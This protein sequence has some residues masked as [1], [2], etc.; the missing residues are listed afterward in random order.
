[1]AASSSSSS[2]PSSL[3][4]PNINF[5]STTT[6]SVSIPGIFLP[7]NRLRY[8]HN[9]PLRIR[10][11]RDDN[12][13]VEDREKAVINGNGSVRLNGNGA[14]RKSINNGDLNGNGRLN[15]SLVKYVNGSVTEEVSKKREE[16]KR[17]KR[18]EDIGQEDAWFK[19]TQQKQQV[20]VSVAPGGRWSR[21]KTYST[22]Q[23]SLEIWG[24]V[25]TF[26]FRTWLSGQKFSY[27]G[28]MTEEKKVLR[29]KVLA[30][31]LKE[32][33]LRLGPTFIKIGQQFSTR[34]DILPQE[35]VDQLSELQD[36]VPPFSSATAL[37][38][39]E[40]ELGASVDDIFDRFDY[41]PIAAA[42][43]GQVHRARLKGQEVVIKVQRPGLKD[44]FDI[45]LK[46]LRVIAEYLQKVDPKSDGAKRDW[47]A[48]YDECA[49]VLYQEIDYTKEA[50]N[51]ELFAN[52]F[53]NLEYVK[54]PSIYWEYTTP[55]VLTMEYVPGIK[56]NKIQA[57]DQLGVDRKRLGRYAVESYLEQ[58]LSHGFF[59]ADPHPGN[60]AVDDVNGGRLIFYD[61]GMMGSI[62][63]NIRE[64]LLEAF[65]GVYEKDPD[66]V[67]Q[68]MVQMGV[69]VPTGDLTSIRRTAL[70]F[71]NSFEERLAAQRKEKEELAAAEELGFKKPLTK[72]EKQEKKKQRLA[73]I[74]EDL[75]AISADQPFRFPATF[76]FV[77]RAFS[78]LDGIGKGLDPR[79]DIT[80][81]AKPYALELLRFREAGVEVV[82]KDLRKRWDRQSQA[83][84]NVFRQADRVEKLAVIIQRLEQG[85]LKLRVRALES[86]RAFQRVAAVQKTVGSAVAAGSLV[87]LATI[88]YLN[89][90]KTPAT[91]AYTVCAFFSLQVLIG[92]IKVKKFDQREKLITGTA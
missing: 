77:V 21:F 40:E 4:L 66:K 27:K 45:D 89:S 34:V 8:S 11:S 58:I 26:I 53:K 19:K 41:E 30:K 92:V 23:R 62:S 49:S 24:F 90:L 70:F 61:F 64:G 47:V 29:R 82:V 56:I 5:H 7:R 81:I 38:I 20:E 44:L 86:E 79:F 51:S 31:W 54:V 22:I 78:V 2:S 18:V 59:H 6:R 42:S 3:L 68:A 76:T 16:E 33:I 52:N 80:E 36:Q 13:A 37:S 73:A 88:L 74:G 25:I 71:L 48:I 10:A 35:Y 15:G 46:N 72:E 55:Q 65:Y 43:L 1:M 84:Y 14:A 87:N 75:L 12:V 17:Q 60:I 32:N 69:L 50:A 28:G 85:D 63:P 67:I 57:L 9:L 39:V 83:F 91:I